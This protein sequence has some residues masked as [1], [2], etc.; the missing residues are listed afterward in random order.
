MLKSIVAVRVPPVP[1]EFPGCTPT[2]SPLL[3]LRLPWTQNLPVLA[4]AQVRM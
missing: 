2:A 4:A 3:R 1:A